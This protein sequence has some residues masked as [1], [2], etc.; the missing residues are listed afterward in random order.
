[1]DD[2]NVGFDFDWLKELAKKADKQG[3][4]D[5]KRAFRESLASAAEETKAVHDAFLAVGFSDE[6]AFE[7]TMS[8][9]EGG[10]NS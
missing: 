9:I 7:I 1:M 8:F 5:R 3:K 10:L 4:A 2:Y 6:Q